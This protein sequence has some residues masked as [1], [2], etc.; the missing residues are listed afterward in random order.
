MVSELAKFHAIDQPCL[1]QWCDCGFGIQILLI[2]KKNSKKNHYDKRNK[3][4]YIQR[5]LYQ[6]EHVS[7]P[8]ITTTY[9][10]IKICLA[11]SQPYKLNRVFFFGFLSFLFYI[12]IVLMRKQFIQLIDRKNIPQSTIT[13]YTTV[14]FEADPTTIGDIGT[15]SRHDNIHQMEYKKKL[16]N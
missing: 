8:K 9:I 11:A 3:D 15:S 2:Q 16:I 1:F 5:S 7:L 10:L 6:S 13:I 4:I 14:L 12:R